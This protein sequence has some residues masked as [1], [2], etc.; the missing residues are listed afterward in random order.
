M[1][2][3]LKKETEWP[4]LCP[5]LKNKCSEYAHQML[6]IP[7]RWTSARGLSTSCF[8]TKKIRDARGK[9][10]NQE[11]EKW[12]RG[13]INQPTIYHSHIYK[14]FVTKYEHTFDYRKTCK[15]PSEAFI[16]VRWQHNGLE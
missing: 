12:G 16:Q 6:Q 15:H 2:D 9:Q 7:S 4:L 3:G 5:R 1:T 13:E 11:G 10:I 14:W 8:P